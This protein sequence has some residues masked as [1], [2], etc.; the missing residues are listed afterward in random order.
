MKEKT[1]FTIY[2]VLLIASFAPFF[3]F[4]PKNPLLTIGWILGDLFA[5]VLLTITIYLGGYFNASDIDE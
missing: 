2:V 1:I 5:L 3:G 4:F